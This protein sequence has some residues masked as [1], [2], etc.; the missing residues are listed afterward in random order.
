MKRTPL[1]RR[2]IARR[3]RRK[4]LGPCRTAPTTVHPTGQSIPVSTR[5]GIRGTRWML[6]YHTGEDYACPVGSQA[7]AVTWGTVLAAGSTSWGPAYGTMVVI[8]TASGRYDYAY[9]HLSHVLVTVGQKVRPG[10][11]VGLTGDTGNVTGPHLHFEARTAGGRY[12]SDVSPR[13]VR[14]SRL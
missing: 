6:G 11:L 8:R 2:M 10:T 3:L 9:C 5:Y 4:A 7:V 12:G 14:R 1:E 13:K